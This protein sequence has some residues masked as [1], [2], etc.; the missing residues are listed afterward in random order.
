MKIASVG[1]IDITTPEALY[2]I[3]ILLMIG[4]LNPEGPVALLIML[5]N[6]PNLG[7]VSFAAL[8]HNPDRLHG[9]LPSLSLRKPI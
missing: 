3:R 4:P 7:C 2:L 5:I 9:R 6:A 1:T 8:P